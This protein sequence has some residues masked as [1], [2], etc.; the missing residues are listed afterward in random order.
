MIDGTGDAKAFT[1][2]IRT[3]NFI[4]TIT[5]E[6]SRDTF[7]MKDFT[8]VKVQGT[9]IGS[10]LFEDGLS[11]SVES[12]VFPGLLTVSIFDEVTGDRGDEHPQQGEFDILAQGLEQVRVVL[13]DFQVFLDVDY[14]GDSTGNGR[15]DADY[16]IDT[17]WADLLNR[18]FL[19]P[20][21]E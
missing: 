16:A 20:V 21:E 7:K 10:Y 6:N 17:I 19:K 12:T 15:F 14:N 9:K 2:E 3:S 4:T 8:L 5:Q 1:H 13:G 11:G 18:D